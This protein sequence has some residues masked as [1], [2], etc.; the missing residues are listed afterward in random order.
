[1]LSYTN[2]C[3]VLCAYPES[4]QLWLLAHPL[5]QLLHAIINLVP[6]VRYFPLRCHCVHLLNLLSNPKLREDLTPPALYINSA[7]YV[8]DVVEYFTSFL[9][10]PDA[11]FK[12]YTGKPPIIHMYMLKTPDKVLGT[13]FFLVSTIVV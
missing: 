1:M 3:Q 11:K 9:E 10:K 8:L 6:T 7:G 12:L 5:A 2:D 13:N 4:Q